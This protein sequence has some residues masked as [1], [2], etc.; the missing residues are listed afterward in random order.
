[1]GPWVGSLPSPRRRLRC[2]QLVRYRETT[3]EPS[4][5]PGPRWTPRRLSI[6]SLRARRRA[7]PRARHR[8]GYR[9]VQRRP[10]AADPPIAGAGPGSP[11]HSLDRGPRPG[12]RL[13][14]IAHRR[15][16]DRR[17]GPDP[18]IGR[19]VR[20]RG[21][22]ADAGARRRPP[23]ADGTGAGVRPVLRR[24]G[25][26]ARAGPRASSGGRCGRRGAGCG[27]EPRRVGPPFRG[28]SRGDRPDPPVARERGELHRRRSDAARPRFPS[29][30]RSLGPDRAR[31]RRGAIRARPM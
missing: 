6:A 30:H 8:P 15:P 10:H 27:A 24:L 7:H 16:R 25:H 19:L 26:P 22:V 3:G 12:V 14:G 28:P 21:G 29:R 5:G 17:R 23:N 18:G 11:G 20:L 4:C 2:S 31:D 1:M 9:G 13:A